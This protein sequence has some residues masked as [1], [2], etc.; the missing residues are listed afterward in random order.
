MTLRVAMIGC[1]AV[2]SI[3]AAN[4]PDSGV[5][6]TTVY[7]PN[8]GEASVFASAYGIK[9]VS[10]SLPEALAMVDAALICSPSDLHFAQ[11]RE[12]V[13][14][15]V[16]TLVELPPCVLTSEA[17]EL[18]DAAHKRGVQLG[19]A[20]T[21][22]YLQPFAHIKT[23]LQNGTVGEI[24]EINYVRYHQLRPRK[25]VDNALFHH[26]AHAIDLVMDWCGGL[27]PLA[28]VAIPSVSAAQAASLLGKLP[29]GG[30]V[31]ISVTY[32]AHLPLNRMLI[33]GKNHTLETDGFS[34][35]RSNCPGLD[36]QAEQA[37]EHAIRDQDAAFLGA[38]QGK[39][40]FVPWGDTVK[41]MRTL[42]R[43]QALCEEP[44]S[45]PN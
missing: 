36:L 32:G 25:W 6:L 30:P 18:R 39:N 22:R 31:A 13:N 1:G 8:I 21:A 16:H 37:Y 28:A 27:E 42:N 15:G 41:L 2:G 34:Y 44:C 4:L 33:I 5:E 14:A 19:C 38:C 20:H 43:V 12:C 40:S 23:N 17:E 29:S 45:S 3:H 7:S 35:V 9:S 11:A 10:G 26:A 24:K